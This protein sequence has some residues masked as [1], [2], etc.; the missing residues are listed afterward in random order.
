MWLGSQLSPNASRLPD[1]VQ[2]APRR[3]VVVGDLGGVHLVR[4]PHAA[5]VEDVEDRVPA[6]GEVLVTRLDPVGAHRREHRDVLPDRRPREADDGL[7]AERAGQPRGVL[8]LLGGALP[9]ALRFTV[10]PHARPDDRLVAEVDRVVADRL[11][12]Q[13]VGDRPEAEPVLVEDRAPL[14]DVVV[15]VP[16]PRVEVLAGDG[17]LET[18][19]APA[20][21]QLGDLRQRQVGPLAGEQGVRRAHRATSRS[22]ALARPCPTLLDRRQHPLHGQP[23]GERRRRLVAGGDRG[24]EVGGLAGERVVPAEDVARR[25]PRR[26][27]TA[28]RP[29]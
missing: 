25:P 8:H 5:L 16:A 18:V 4:E 13:V 24:E 29:R 21:R 28:G 7:H 6:V 22:I 15:V 14:G 19:V 17:D 12:G 20:G 11:P 26:R 27:R 9:H 1:G 3:P 23:V 2:R 10:A